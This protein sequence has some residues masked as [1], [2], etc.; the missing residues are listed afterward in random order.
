VY[1]QKAAVV[2]NGLGIVR[3]LELFNED[4]K[5][6]HPETPIAKQTNNP[7]LDKEIGDSTALK[8]VLNDFRAARHRKLR[9]LV[10][11]LIP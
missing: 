6:N 9:S 1:V 3:H 8:P 5:K 10:F 4:F 7:E 2:S 11:A